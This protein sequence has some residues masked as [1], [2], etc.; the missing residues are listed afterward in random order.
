MKKVGAFE[1]KTNL[2]KLLERAR[3]GESIA[4][5][6]HG[7]EVAWL[8]PPPGRQVQPDVSQLWEQWTKSRKGLTLGGLKVR[9]LINEGRR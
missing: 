3:S 4:I 2:S 5:T 8:V 1:A 9:D 7:E 6:R